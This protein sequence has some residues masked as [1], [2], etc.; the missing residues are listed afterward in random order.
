M[1]VG[2]F[3]GS[4]TGNTENFAHIIMD[5]LKQLDSTLQFEVYMINIEMNKKNTKPD[6]QYPNCDAYLFGAYA[7][8]YTIPVFVRQYLEAMPSANLSGKYV[9][10]FSTCGS[11]MRNMRYVFEQIL[12]AHGALPVTYVSAIYPGNY[13]HIQMAYANVVKNQKMVDLKKNCAE[14]VHALKTNTYIRTQQ[15]K[16]CTQGFTDRMQQK[17]IPIIFKI[18][19]ACIGCGTCVRN[20]PSGILSIENKKA[21]FTEQE[22]CVGCYA[23][24]QKCPVHAVVDEKKK[25]A[26]IQQY[27]FDA[28]L[29][30]K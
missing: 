6:Y 15:T 16:S 20:C 28:K 29:I 14:F 26:K 24:F 1:K 5:E 30:K 22:K 17:A 12:T 7:D 13:V 23:C 2:V 25:L 21:V 9:M 3:I 4:I 10:T 27:K 18:D 11:N 19:S 8:W